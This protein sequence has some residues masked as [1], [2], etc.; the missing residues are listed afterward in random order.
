MTVDLTATENAVT[1]AIQ[2]A[3][4]ALWAS[5]AAAFEGKPPPTGICL[6]F[7]R[8]TSGQ[9]QC[10]RVSEQEAR[11]AVAAQLQAAGILFSIETPTSMAYCL[12][13]EGSRSAQTDLT[14]YSAHDAP[15]LNVEFKAG[16]VSSGRESVFP[17]SKDLQ[18]IVREERDAIWFHLLES[19]N[20]STLLNL[21]QVLV[22][23]LRRNVQ[24]HGQKT[25]PKR[26][27][28]HICVLRH[29]FAVQRV[30]H[31]HPALVT[32]AW[33]TDMPMFEH[34]VSRSDLIRVG[35][36]NGWEVVR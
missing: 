33:L 6:Q 22:D 14:I 7:A 27:Q 16:G 29:Q 19:V 36:A 18:K 3:D 17:I 35:E 20:N 31:L 24:E 21:W 1:T 9:T 32:E 2:K 12:T 11:F 15:F 30:L 23:E 34:E 10:V 8:Y 4:R 25:K 28:I 5:Y 26:L 13:G